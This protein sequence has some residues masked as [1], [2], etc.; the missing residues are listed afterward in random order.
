MEYRQLGKSTL[1]I[2]RI[3]F[4][5]MSLPLQENAVQDLLYSA[6]DKGINFLDTADLYDKGLNEAV[7]GQA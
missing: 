7:I 5:A 6:F 1:R 4:G 2:S 3:G